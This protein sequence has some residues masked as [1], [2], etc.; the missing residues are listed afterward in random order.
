MQWPSSCCNSRG[1]VDSQTWWGSVDA[2]AADTPVD[3]STP[4]AWA[5][6]AGTPADCWKGR[7]SGCSVRTSSAVAVGVACWGWASPS[8][9][10]STRVDIGPAGRGWD[11]EAFAGV[12]WRLRTS[13]V[14]L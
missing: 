14:E 8:A 11:E 7:A 12:A 9:C 10:R 6:D 13:V 4:A 1:R 3:R 2:A 5:A